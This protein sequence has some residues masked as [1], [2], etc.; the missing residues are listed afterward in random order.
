[1]VQKWGF[2]PAGATRCSDKREIWHGGVDLG[3]APPYQI[4]RLS[5]QRVAPTG[6]K[7]I[8]GP[9]SKNNTGMAALRAG[10]PVKSY[11]TTTGFEHTT[12]AIKPEHL[13]MPTDGGSR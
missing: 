13:A 6:R 8:F 12:Y 5:G 10:L 4:S 7:T 9:L 3:S 11:N 1:M 2:R